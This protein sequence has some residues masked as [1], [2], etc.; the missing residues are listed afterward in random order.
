MSIININNTDDE[1]YRYKMPKVLIK[2]GGCGNGIYTTIDNMDEIAE[3]LN[4]PSEVI[5]KFISYNLG[6]AFN[7]KKKLFTGHHN[8]I[9]DI[10]FEYINFFVIC[11]SCTIP[12][13][14]Y[15]LDKINSKKYNLISKC[16]ACGNVHIVE[17][18]NKFNEKCI[19]TI[20]K[21]MQKN[22]SWINKECNLF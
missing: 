16:S 5:Y 15:S 2:L 10:I 12:E 17:S 18:T 7:E 8:N 11:P 9:Q 6:S 3:S 14:S 13:L 1:F 19:E 21:F 20:I 4:T 22:N